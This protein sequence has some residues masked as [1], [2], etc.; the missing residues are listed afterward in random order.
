M[1]KKDVHLGLEVAVRDP[2]K[3]VERGEIAGFVKEQGKA[4]RYRVELKSGRSKGREIEVT[5]RGLV[6][7]WAH[8]EPFHEQ[9]RRKILR[10]EAERIMAEQTQAEKMERLQIIREHLVLHG[11]HA[12][13]GNVHVPGQGYDAALF[14]RFDHCLTLDEILSRVAS[15]ELLGPQSPEKNDD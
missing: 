12:S 6:A 13:L 11:I 9:A 1:L 8:Y 2:W 4:D 3:S 15:A 14:I 7:P 10:A 5:S